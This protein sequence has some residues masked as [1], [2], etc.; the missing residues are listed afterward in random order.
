MGRR[1]IALPVIGI[2]P[3]DDPAPLARTMARVDDYRLAIFVSPNAIRQAIAH[4]VDPWPAATTIG[5]MGPGSVETLKHLG[6]AAPRHRVVAPVE[7]TDGIGRFDSESLFAVLDATLGLTKGFADRVLILRGNGGRA[8]FADRLRAL[9]I[10]VDEVEAY[11]RVVPAVD[12]V[13]AA[14]LTELHGS[15]DPAVFIVTSSEGVQNL[16]TLVEAALP[17]VD[18]K[19]WLL[20]QP[21]LAPHRRIAEKAREL[22]FSDVSL[23]APGD[24]GILAAI[25]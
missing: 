7:A 18:A 6:I 24:R 8:W 21:L 22:G 10:G 3:V 2:L 19:R 15:T 13:V 9:G 1:V 5:V 11:R 23:C 17:G 25:E 16:V 20:G 4:R 14:A 12:P